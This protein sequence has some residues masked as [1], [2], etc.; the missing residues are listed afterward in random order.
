MPGYKFERQRY[1]FDPPALV[2]ASD[3]APRLGPSGPGSQIGAPDLVSHLATP[4]PGSRLGGSD[5]G[6]PVAGADPVEPAILGI[7]RELFD[8]GQIGPND[9]F[10][11]LG[12]DSLLA[13]QLLAR[14]RQRFTV[15][16]ALDALF[17]N[18]TPRTLAAVVDRALIERIDAISDEEAEI[19][20]LTDEQVDLSLR[21][22][23]KE[24]S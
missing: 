20:S 14:I 18:T 5:P 8:N 2:S 7:W 23:L 11:D 12:G 3:P 22:L 19:D 6:S 24:R 9:E 17:D 1:W 16:I 4:G 10:F 21:S 15:E 13:V